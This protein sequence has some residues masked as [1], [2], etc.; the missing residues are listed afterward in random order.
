[1]DAAVFGGE[2]T[3]DVGI[4]SRLLWKEED[5]VSASSGGGGAFVIGIDSRGC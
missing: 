1:M 2:S 5:V 4:G 3:E